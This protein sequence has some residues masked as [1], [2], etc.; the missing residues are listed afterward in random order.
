MGIVATMSI[1]WATSKNLHFHL[2]YLCSKVL[3]AH[4]LRELA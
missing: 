2:S 4:G 1:S 3:E